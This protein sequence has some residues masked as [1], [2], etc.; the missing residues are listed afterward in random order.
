[1]E[2][3]LRP[4]RTIAPSGALAFSFGCQSLQERKKW[5]HCA[6]SRS[7][8]RGQQSLSV[9]RVTTT[10]CISLDL[11]RY[12]PTPPPIAIHDRAKETRTSESFFQK[13][14]SRSPASCPQPARTHDWHIAEGNRVFRAPIGIP[15][16]S[17]S[18]SHPRFFQAPSKWVYS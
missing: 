5:Q 13:R 4:L 16:E 8:C 18:F 3:T 17:R 14:M 9:A 7:V 15:A 1:M 11:R 2:P 6:V 12:A 10:P